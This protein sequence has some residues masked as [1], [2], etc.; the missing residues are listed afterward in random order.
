MEQLK[1]YDKTFLQWCNELKNDVDALNAILLEMEYKISKNIIITFEE[2]ISYRLR[3]SAL[4]TTKRFSEKVIVEFLNRKMEIDLDSFIEGMAI[5][6]DY[7][8]QERGK[9]REE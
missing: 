7:L 6:G 1:I 8:K 3:I 2:S 9:I 4:N 5:V